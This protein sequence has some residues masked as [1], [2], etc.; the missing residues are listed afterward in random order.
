MK[1]HLLFLSFLPVL[2]IAC[3]SAKNIT[4][5]S[6]TSTPSYKEYKIDSSYKQKPAVVRFIQPYSAEVYKQMNAVIGETETPL[7]RKTPEGTLGNFVADAMLQRAISSY[8]KTIDASFANSGGLRLDDIAK[9]PIALGKIYELMPFDNIIVLISLKGTELLQLL[10]FIAAKK[11]WPV[12]GIK[13]QIKDGKSIHQTV[14]GKPINPSAVYTIAT[15]DYT[16]NGNEGADFL[17]AFKQENNGYLLREAL[18][19]Y[20]KD[21]TKQGRKITASIE[22]R[23]TNAE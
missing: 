21:A 16:A 4:G 15:T 19:D 12:S 7:F 18:I 14:N 10:D 1:S 11:G 20:V 5:T 8:N 3:R 2:L 22:N 6:T 23:I 9:G 13:M 17:K